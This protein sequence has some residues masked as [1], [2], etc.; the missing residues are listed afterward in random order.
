VKTMSA[1]IF[2]MK[3][4]EDLSG[5]LPNVKIFLMKG[6]EEVVKSF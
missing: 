4:D 6:D 2:L 1:K 3:G 5:N